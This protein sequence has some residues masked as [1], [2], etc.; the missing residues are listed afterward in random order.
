MQTTQ[1]PIRS[2]I[3]RNIRSRVLSGLLVL[4][5]VGMTLLI[6]RFLFH[7]VANALQPLTDRLFETLPDYVVTLLSIAFWRFSSILPG[8]SPLMSWG[9]G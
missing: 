8:W 9:A 6:L 1:L 5:P 2:R 3:Q 7:T 4:V